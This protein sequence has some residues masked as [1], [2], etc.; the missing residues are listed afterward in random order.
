MFGR[1]VQR[2]SWR[3]DDPAT[4]AP[5]REERRSLTFWNTPS[6][7]RLL[8]L[9]L[10]FHAAHGDVTFGDTEEGGLCALRVP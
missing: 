8:D 10:T 1:I 6:T 5:V 2:V 4:G 7:A 3:R 9:A